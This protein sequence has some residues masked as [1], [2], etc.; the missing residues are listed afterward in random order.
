MIEMKNVDDLRNS[1]QG[2][3]VKDYGDFKRKTVTYLNRF[4]ELNKLNDDQLKHL[5]FLKWYIQFHPNYQLAET[6]QWTLNQVEK[7]RQ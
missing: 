1:I 6:K 4:S 3:V 2:I 5:Q 7:F